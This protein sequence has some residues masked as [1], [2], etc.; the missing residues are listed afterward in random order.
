MDNLVHFT[1]G[2][3]TDNPYFSAGAGLFGVGMGVALLR[4]CGQ[5]ASVLLRRNLT[6]T[7]EIASHDSSYQWVMH[8]LSK[9]ARCTRDSRLQK[10]A[11]QHFS[12]ETSVVRTEAGRIKAAFEFIPST[13]V[14]YLFYQGRILRVERIRSQQTLQG[15]S[16][17]PFESVTL[18]TLGFDTQIFRD[19]LEEAR[20][21]AI[22][23]DKG[24]TVIYKAFG[25]EWRQ[26]GYPRPRRPLNSVVL[27]E[28]V[29]ESITADIKEFI[30]SPDWYSARGIPYRRGYL[31]YGPPGCGKS[32]FITALAGHLEYNICV[33]NLSDLGMSADRLD[34]LLTHAPLQSIIL[35]EDID[36]ALPSREEPINLAQRYGRAYEG[37]QGLTMSGLLNALDGVASTD[38]RILFMTTN[39]VDRLDP[40]LVRPGRVDFKAEIG[41]CTEDQLSRMFSRFYPEKEVVEE[42]LAVSFAAAL[43]GGLVSAAQVQGF[44]LVHKSSP[45]SAM[46]ALPEFRE[47]CL[48]H[49]DKS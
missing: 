30:S 13:G 44:L 38:G 31:L 14:H 7:M 10:G 16:V 42:S 24:W 46:D 25:S 43:G 39:Y 47:K 15:A 20:C 4:R 22:A 40:A 28:G 34:H 33:L 2:I 27:G 32:S 12:V 8:W 41:L 3:F 9:R 48:L 1:K 35:L 23:K 26:F 6:L 49:R 45:Q 37:M 29:A 21:A 5:V 17:A 11:G 19:I 36:A 18:T